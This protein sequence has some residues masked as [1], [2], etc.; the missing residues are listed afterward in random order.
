MADS[1]LGQNTK[2]RKF[3]M[4]LTTWLSMAVG[5]CL[6][7]GATVLAV[8]PRMNHTDMP[9]PTPDLNQFSTFKPVAATT[10]RDSVAAAFAA[11]PTLAAPVAT[12]VPAPKATAKP[13]ES[14]ITGMVV[15]VA[16]SL[17][18][19]YSVQTL[20]YSTTLSQWMTHNGLDFV[21]AEGTPVKS[22]LAG[23]VTAIENHP[24]MG[25]TVVMSHTGSV[26]TRYAGLQDDI[27][28]VVGSTLNA[29]QTLGRVGATAIGEADAGPHL[30]FEV[31]KSGK[32]LN[33]ADYLPEGQE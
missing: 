3:H 18:T 23:T 26:E 16:G 30:H 22:A 25:I 19:P 10:P 21:A 17:G 13:M 32:C 24:L 14:A 27:T 20:V 9:Q 5:F 12:P 28:L 2:K 8:W 4:D 1:P 31:W 7:V 29:G 15:P 6:V 33:P 11:R